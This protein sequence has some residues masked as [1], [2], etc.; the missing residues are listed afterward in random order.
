[1]SNLGLFLNPQIREY[2]DANGLTFTHEEAETIN[3]RVNDYASIGDDGGVR[4]DFGQGPMVS[5]QAAIGAMAVGHG[6]TKAASK[7]GTSGGA[8]PT[9]GSATERALALNAINRDGRTAA[10]AV[11]AQRLVDTHGSPW[12]P[13]TINKTR[14]AIISNFDP[15][16]ATRLKRQAGI[17]G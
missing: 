1:M 12:D 7:G 2:A 15:S 4:F 8:I 10:Q 3:S 14:Q 11:E 16:L 13:R 6:K 9:G 17:R 5:V